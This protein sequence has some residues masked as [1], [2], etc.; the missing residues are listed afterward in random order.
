MI[1][2]DNEAFC[3]HSFRPMLSHARVVVRG[4]CRGL[5][6]LETGRKYRESIP[7]PAPHHRGDGAMSRAIPPESAFDLAVAPGRSI[8]LKIL[9]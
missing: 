2:Y 3:L 6:D 7:L 4:E 9:R 5:Q 8:Y 1:S